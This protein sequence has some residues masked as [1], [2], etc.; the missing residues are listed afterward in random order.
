[1]QYSLELSGMSGDAGGRGMVQRAVV[2]P[3]DRPVDGLMGGEE[4]SRGVP[5]LSMG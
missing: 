4:L 3:E 2:V 1:M 5:E